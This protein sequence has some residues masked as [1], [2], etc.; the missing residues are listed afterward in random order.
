[1]SVYDFVCV[2]RG[3]VSLQA[4]QGG[5]GGSRGNPTSFATPGRKATSTPARHLSFQ[6][7][8][9]AEQQQ[10]VTSGLCCSLGLSRL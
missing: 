5:S 8:S 7:A 1:M 10:P 2:S 6:Q 9:P 4:R 3:L